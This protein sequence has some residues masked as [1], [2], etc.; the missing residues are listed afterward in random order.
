MEEV[1]AMEKHF[2]ENKVESSSNEGEAAKSFNIKVYFHVIAQNNTQAGGNIPDTQIRN[3]IQVLNRGYSTAGV[4]WTLAGVDLT[5]N[6]DWYLNAGPG[7]LQQTTMKRT[8]RKGGSGDFNVYTVG[9]IPSGRDDSIL[10]Y[11]T[12][13]VSYRSN[14]LDDG[15]IVRAATLPGGSAAPYNL[16][17]LGIGSAYTIPSKVDV[18]VL[19]TPLPTPLLKPVLPLDVP[20]EEIL[21]PAEAPIRS[22]SLS[23]F[24]M[25]ERLFR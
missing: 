23:I 19:G 25:W 24:Y 12:F 22:V 3:Q 11:A 2:M 16:G 5:V 15:V 18:L 13:P 1:A 10:G 14:A 9:R 20:T 21:A 6:A 7:T 8:L 4:T 17:Q